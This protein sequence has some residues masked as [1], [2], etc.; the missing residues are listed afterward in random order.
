M[1]ELVAGETLF[2]YSR[3]ENMEKVFLDRLRQERLFRNVD[4][5]NWTRYVVVKGADGNELDAWSPIPPDAFPLVVSWKLADADADSWSHGRMR[6][7]QRISERDEDA[8]SR[9]C[10]F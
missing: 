10:S 5:R 3:E 9:Q 8:P 6:H 7:C 4:Q 1:G 2:V